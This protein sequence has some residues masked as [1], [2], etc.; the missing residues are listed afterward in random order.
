LEIQFLPQTGVIMKLVFA[1]ITAAMLTTW[2]TAC[3]DVVVPTRGEHP[4]TSPD[5]VVLFDRATPPKRYEILGSVSLV[6]TPQLRWDESGDAN[7]AY[8]QLIQQAAALGATGLFF[9]SKIPGTTITSLAG[10]HGTMYEVPIHIDPTTQTRTALAT[11]IWV[12]QQR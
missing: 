3:S 11:A 2:F 1:L 6:I 12:V 10:Y 7:A 9:D 5:Q 4:P 8:T